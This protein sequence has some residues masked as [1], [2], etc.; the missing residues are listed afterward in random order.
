MVVSDAHH[1]RTLRNNVSKVVEVIENPLLGES[2][3]SAELCFHSSK[4]RRKTLV[5]VPW[6]QFLKVAFSIFE[7][8]FGHKDVSGEFIAFEVL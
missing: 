2:T 5:H 4:L 7:A 8:I 6:S 1:R 3:R